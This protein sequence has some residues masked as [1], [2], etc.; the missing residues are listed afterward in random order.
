MLGSEPS[1]GKRSHGTSLR[2]TR[3]AIGWLAAFVA[4]IVLSSCT[5]LSATSTP[6]GAQGVHSPDAQLVSDSTMKPVALYGDSL[7]GQS[8]P[9]FSRFVKRA[10]GSSPLISTLDGTAP[11]DALPGLL[12]AAKSRALSIA[13]IDFSGNSLTPCMTGAPVGSPTYF[14]RYRIDIWVA[15]MALVSAGT[16]V[17]LA[18]APETFKQAQQG[19]TSWEWLNQMLASVAN[20]D[21]A[22]VR[23]V[24]AGESVLDHG[25]FTWSLPCLRDEP[26]LNQPK[27]GSNFVRAPDGAHFCPHGLP[28]TQ[29]VV[30]P[31]AEYMSGA[32][33]YGTAMAAAALQ[34]L[35]RR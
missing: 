35:P 29:G 8:A 17:V 11:C 26:C 20:S 28:A 30:G 3:R 4:T 16:N 32:F 25:Q 23:F 31:C 12:T 13:V 14:L 21:P 18:G 24:N 2:T 1:G 9:Y 19:G 5:T 34:M 15:T 10:D 27:R 6:G 7:A 33:R 22:H